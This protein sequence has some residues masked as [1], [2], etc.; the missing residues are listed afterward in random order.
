MTEGLNWVPAPYMEEAMEFVLKR[1]GSGLMLDPGMRKTSITLA[2]I[3]IL[4]SVGEIRKT[5]VVAP[6]RVCYSVW[7]KEARKWAN[8][9]HLKVCNLCNLTTEIRKKLLAEDFDIY[10]INP[11]VVQPKGK[12]PGVFS[13][14]GDD[15]DFFVADEST[16]FKDTSTLRFKALKKVIFNFKRRL[17]LTGTCIPNGLQDLFGQM[18]IVDFGASLGKFI[19]HFRMEFCHQRPG[20]LYGWHLNR[21]A[22]E[23]IY[24]RVDQRL[25]R[26]ETKGNIDL[27]PLVRNF[28]PVD[29]PGHLKAAYRDLKKDFV[30]QME[31][32]TVAVF[33][34]SA[35][36][37]KLRQM[38]NGF[39]YEGDGRGRTATR[40]HT[41]KL[42]ALE[43]LI[44]E[45][46]G[47]PLLVAYEFEEDEAMIAERFPDAINLGKVKDVDKTIDRFNAGQ[48]PV[49]YAHP[50]S[51]GHGLNMQ[52]ACSTVCWYGITWNYEFYTQFNARVHRSGQ[53][54]ATTVVHH[55]VC[56]GTKDEDVMQTLESKG[57]TQE[58]FN[59]AIRK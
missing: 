20:D 57:A 41:E 50:A 53:T 36:G 45:M 21:N 32:K 58:A 14:L 31:E 17:I 1:D 4:K 24:K 37:T 3:D 34:P 51:V 43:E 49:L 35:V 39:I 26:L 47:R 46:Q 28:I 29:L 27:P 52:E 18:Y 15:F 22:P 54:A 42:D 44:E 40:L 5:L 6:L 48:I 7:P 11:D 23:M 8:F 38:A 16:K 25:M 10:L 33:N 30:A 13:L 55:I 56:T 12:N 9:R 59:Q 2:V 19:T